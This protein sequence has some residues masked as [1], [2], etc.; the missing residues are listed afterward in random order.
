VR[1][2]IIALAVVSMLAT[3]AAAQAS[4]PADLEGLR[5]AH[6][7]YGPDVRGRLTI[8]ERGDGRVADLA[9]F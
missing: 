2:P 6:A 7:R 4:G 1:R 5:V 9:G 8:F 3:V